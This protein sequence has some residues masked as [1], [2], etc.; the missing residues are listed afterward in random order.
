ME[1]L[2]LVIILVLFLVFGDQ[3]DDS[4]IRRVVRSSDVY[5]LSAEWAS[6]LVIN[7]AGMNICVKQTVQRLH[8]GDIVERGLA[9]DYAVG[10]KTAGAV[11]KTVDSLTN[12][13]KLS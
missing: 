13:C 3:I 6:V 4:T 11:A 10:K 9:T 8:N 1:K 12:T 7:K 5:A 2:P